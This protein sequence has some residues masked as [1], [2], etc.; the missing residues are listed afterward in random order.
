M[1]ELVLT[2]SFGP[3]VYT[4]VI[5]VVNGQ[6][7]RRAADLLAR[8]YIHVKHAKH[9]PLAKESERPADS[10]SRGSRMSEHTTTWHSKPTTG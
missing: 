10:G 1:P 9:A 6:Q 7:L 5:A 2:A 3:E 4:D 8:R